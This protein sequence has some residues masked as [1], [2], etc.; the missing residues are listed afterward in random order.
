MT[1]D[2][3]IVT[4]QKSYGYDTWYQNV[5]VKAILSTGGTYAASFAGLGNDQR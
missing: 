2:N 3:G 1:Y 5:N 4:A